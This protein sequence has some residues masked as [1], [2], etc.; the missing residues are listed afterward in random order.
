[1][2]V[3]LLL[4][5]M[6]ISTSLLAQINLLNITTADNA[7]NVELNT[8]I[9][10]EF[11]QA[12]DTL[13]GFEFFQNFFTNIDEIQATWFSADLKIV[14]LGVNLEEDKNYYFLVYS[15]TGPDNSSLENP[16]V[17]YFTTAKKYRFFSNRKKN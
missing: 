7:T 10:I 17:V 12:I 8:T 16:T 1:M 13:K 9:S 11:D 3:K 14:N 4:T 5:I 2:K 6:L 15:V